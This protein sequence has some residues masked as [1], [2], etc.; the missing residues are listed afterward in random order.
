MS[1]T[2]GRHVVLSLRLVIALFLVAW[3]AGHSLHHG[4]HAEDEHHHHGP[5]STEFALEASAVP[6]VLGPAVQHHAAVALPGTAEPSVS[7]GHDPLASHCCETQA[8]AVKRLRAKAP[9]VSSPVLPVQWGVTVPLHS[10]L[11]LPAS[12][13][14]VLAQTPAPV[15]LGVLRH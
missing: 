4:L 11:P 2:A 1:Q 9:L 5:S 14:Q 6:S 7:H 8:G 12:L 10:D 15:E 3:L 13:G